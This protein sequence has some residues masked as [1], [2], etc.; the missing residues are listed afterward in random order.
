MSAST[1]ELAAA[2]AHHPELLRAINALLELGVRVRG[3]NG[4]YQAFR[5]VPGGAIRIMGPEAPS[6]TTA[7]LMA[8]ETLSAP[9]PRKQ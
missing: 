8:W 7:W 5:N 6:A 9:N 3:N 1:A 4:I 2:L